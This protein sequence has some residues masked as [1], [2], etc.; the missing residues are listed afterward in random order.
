MLGRSV[1]FGRAA[2]VTIAV[3]TGATG[4]L[5]GI[6]ASHATYNPHSY[7]IGSAALLMLAC[8]ALAGLSLNR[9]RLKQRLAAAERRIENLV[10]TTWELREAQDRA[11]HLLDAHGDIIVRRD[12]AGRV[13]FANQAYRALAQNASP[14]AAA[15][16][17]LEQ[18]PAHMLD[19]GTR[20]H[21]QKIATPSGA[22]WIA[23]REVVVR[24]DAGAEVQA[25]G[26]DITERV[27][28]EQ[29]LTDARDAAEAANRAKSRFLATVSHEIRTPLN[30]ILGMTGLLLDSK[31]TP[32]QRT[33]ATA[34]K[35]SGDNL[36]SLI[37]DMLDFSKIEAGKLDLTAQPLS[38]T[39]L[40]EDVVELLA[41]RAH[42]KGIEIASC[43][44]PQ[45]PALVIGDAARL[46]Q[47]LLNLAGNAI[48]FTERGG[49]SITVAPSKRTGAG[50]HA[51]D[52]AVRDSGI[53]LNAAD[54][55]RIFEE[56]EQADTGTTRRYG[57]T[58]LGLAI[59]KRI[60][61]RM[62]GTLG[63]DSAPGA[64]ATF[65]A[66]VT[67]PPADPQAATEP[68]PILDTLT[69]LIAT[70]GTTEAALMAHRLRRW[71]ALCA[72]VS[73][74][75]T[76]ESMLRQQAWDVI[77]SDSALAGIAASDLGG[78]AR[79]IALL[80][81]DRRDAIAALKQ[82]G[83]ASY[84]IKPVRA[85]SLAAAMQT[86]AFIGAIGETAAD[87]VDDAP[88]S[89]SDT[90]LSILVGE[91]NPINAL[92][93]RTL[94]ARMGHRPV[95]A[96]DGAATLATWRGARGAGAPFDLVLMD[97]HMPAM[98]G[99]AATRAIRQEEQTGADAP[100]TPIIA[101]TA[102]AFDDDRQACRD[103]GMDG[104]LL[105]P[106]QREA[107]AAAMREACGRTATLA[108]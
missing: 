40:V 32:E 94:L 95:M 4:F 29:A 108:A 63:V 42:G 66:T 14:D 12:A 30:G 85:A 23:W 107:L 81:P 68:A 101:L 89:G 91:D 15:L 33:Y 96:A 34:A 36:L 45:V 22:R 49:V 56:F 76:A 92:L 65:T 51:L 39:A 73:D 16:Q 10:D 99:L 53:G 17:I 79:R 64:G 46:R 2:V 90:S 3:F 98:D 80:T 54:Q 27:T 31:L 86:D 60:V 71:G 8:I 87:T 77:V 37:E 57:G 26:R 48:K 88:E 44:E 55:A 7:A 100:R 59:S 6:Q 13:T 105:K 70:T 20:I 5:S 106:L 103:A 102:Y 104:F 74:A 69:V 93:A 18:S 19:D 83:F 24:G 43:V 9:R 52:I 25:V 67:L 28:T 75:A 84:L 50:A 47:V 11:A 62:G 58:G 61:A 72:V 38:L 82:Q 97:V 41:P 21:D 35:T 78:S 1:L